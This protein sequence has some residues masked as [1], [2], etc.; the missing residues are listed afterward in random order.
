MVSKAEPQHFLN[1]S[2]FW[3]CQLHQ[4]TAILQATAKMLITV[5]ACFLPGDT[6]GFGLTPIE[7]NS[8]PLSVVARL[9]HPTEVGTATRASS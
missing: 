9:Y 8:T 5:H 3:E 1:S 7:G 2:A 6:N 4:C